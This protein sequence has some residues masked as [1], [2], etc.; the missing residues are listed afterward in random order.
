MFQTWGSSVAVIPHSIWLEAQTK[1]PGKK[2]QGK[3]MDVFPCNFFI[4]PIKVKSP[5]SFSQKESSK[6][7]CTRLG[8]GIEELLWEA[9]WNVVGWALAKGLVREEPGPEKLCWNKNFQNW[10]SLPQ[11]EIW[12]EGTCPDQIW[13]EDLVPLLCILNMKAVWQRCRYHANDESRQYMA[14]GPQDWPQSLLR[15]RCSCSTRCT[16]CL[17]HLACPSTLKQSLCWRGGNCSHF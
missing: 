8:K 13:Q 4:C 16:G 14:W 1:V 7:L 12:M 15:H 6:S 9:G 5:V 17:W 10:V 3:N 2:G 11:R